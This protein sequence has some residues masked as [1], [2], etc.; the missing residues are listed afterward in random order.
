MKKSY[1]FLM[2]VFLNTY[3]FSQV[4]FTELA[5]PD[6]NYNA[7]FIEIY[8]AGSTAVDFT[9]G[10]GWRIDKYTNAS[11]TADK[12]LYLT[13]T[14]EPGG[15]YIIAYDIEPGTFESV[16]GFAPNQLDAVEYGVA[17]SN[18]DDDLFLIDGTGAVVDAYG[19]PGID[20]TGQCSEYEDGRA[21]RVAS[22]TEGSPVWDESEWNVWADSAP[23]ETCTN[24]TVEPQV[25]PD[26][27]DPG[28]W[29]GA[30][31]SNTIVSFDSSSI[32]VDED[33]GTVDVCLTITNPDESN[34]TV[35]LINMNEEEST[36]SNG[37][38]F[39]FIDFPYSV[40]FPAGSSDPQCISIDITDDDE[41]EIAETLT[42][43]I[44]SV[45][46]G[47]EAQA[48]T[49]LQFTLTIEHN[50]VIPPNPGDIIITEIMA[51]P[52]AVPDEDGEYFEVY[53]TTDEP[54]DML[55]WELTD[56]NSTAVLNNNVMGS[57]TNKTV[58]PANGYLVFCTNG[59]P[60]ENGGIQVDYDFD[61]SGTGLINDGGS[62]TLTAAGV[63]IDSVTW[64]DGTEFP[65]VEGASMEL[66]MNHYD[67]TLNDDGANWC[68]AVSPYGDGDLGTPGTDNDCALVTEI[69][70]NAIAGF[71]VY[72]NP[73]HNGQ[74]T[75]YTESHAPKKVEVYNV[76]GKLLLVKDI[77]EAQTQLNLRNL[78]SG[79]YMLKVIE[80]DSVSV[81]KLL[82]K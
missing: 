7:R 78:K 82:I 59:D 68:E 20:N 56:T 41:V 28:F 80:G 71:K 48:I 4:F 15:F 55:A 40:T 44:D 9:E 76:A 45:S 32:V 1:F 77:S 5:D 64:D 2:M 62:L 33:A 29:I 17:G 50:D 79:I 67:A 30:P 16:Y 13:G 46:G 31:V 70:E 81:E 66:S 39:T 57:I 10:D 60:D 18:G 36:A 37:D 6:N 72:P 53:N 61:G 14:I 49:P 19:E 58:V 65:V 51:N 12:T 54:I 75:I 34:D 42:L 35:V 8:N 69:K 27:Y 63:V 3:A 23:D 74:I 25:A 11:D 22:V 52:S 47:N 38:D 21:E 43:Y 73:V 26:D 24:F